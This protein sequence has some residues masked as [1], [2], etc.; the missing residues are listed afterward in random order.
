M[1]LDV[2]RQLRRSETG[3]LFL[4]RSVNSGA[5]R[6]SQIVFFERLGP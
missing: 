4:E 6:I 5:K 2:G 1:S 3:G